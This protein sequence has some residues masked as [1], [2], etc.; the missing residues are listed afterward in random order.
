MDGYD[1][2]DLRVLLDRAA[3][4]AARHAI[5]QPAAIRQAN[6]RQLAPPLPNGHAEPTIGPAEA[7]EELDWN[8]PCCC[9][10]LR[11]CGNQCRNL[12]RRHNDTMPSL[13]GWPASHSRRRQELT[14]ACGRCSRGKLRGQA[15]DR[16]GRPAGRAGGLHAGSLLGRRQAVRRR[17]H[18]AG[19][20]ALLVMAPT[21]W[22]SHE[23]RGRLK[24]VVNHKRTACIV[25]WLH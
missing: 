5:D 4:S 9:G 3:L 14:T 22:P 15:E 21:C 8:L 25:Q 6:N 12:A 2:A 19:Q 10:A 17:R 13:F 7:G 1:A 11:A 18:C 24:R 16:R 20:I 23:S